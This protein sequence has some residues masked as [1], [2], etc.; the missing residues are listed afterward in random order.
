MKKVFQ[1]ISGIITY[2]LI[3]LIFSAYDH[4][5]TH[6]EINHIITVK[7][8][9]RY[10]QLSFG[11]GKFKYFT[12][13][14]NNSS[15]PNL[16]GPALDKDYYLSYTSANEPIKSL[17]PISWITQG[18]WMED[19]PWATA[20]VRH[21]YDPLAI[22]NGKKYLS[23]R[24]SLWESLLSPV[25]SLLTI[26]AET[27]VY[28]HPD[29]KYSFKKAKEYLINAL[30]ETNTAKKNEYMA[31]AYRSLGQVLHLI[32]DMGCPPHVRNDSHPPNFYAS[33]A[34]AEGLNLIKVMGDPDP[35][36]ELVKTLSIQSLVESSNPNSNLAFQF[37]KAESFKEI[38]EKLA[39]LTNQRLVTN[40]TISTTYYKQTIRPDNPYP[41]P[42]ISEN[43]YNK[44]D[45]IY[46]KN[47]D[48]INVKM[49]KDKTPILFGTTYG[50]GKPYV[51]FDCVKSQAMMIM[52]NIVEAGVNVIRQ[53]IP[54]LKIEITQAV[55]DSGGIVRGK[56]SYTIP[57]LNDEYAG[58][59]ELSN[60]YNGPVKLKIN[61]NE[62][63]VTANAV[64]NNFEI[65]LNGSFSSLK[66]GDKA[67]VYIDLGGITLKS[68]SKEFIGNLPQ[69][70]SINPTSA[71]VNDIITINGKYFGSSSTVGKV[72]FNSIVATDVVSWSDLKIEVK[73][74]T[75]AQ[76]G[77][78]YVKVNNDESNKVNFTLL[79]NKPIINS[80]TPSTAKV[81]DIIKISGDNFGDNKTNGSIVFTGAVASSTDII[82]WNNKE[83]QVKVPVNTQ[84]GDIYIIVNS[85]KSNVF[86][87]T[88]E[89]PKDV[90]KITSLSPA[91][92]IF[93]VNQSVYI[94]GEKFGTDKNKVKIELNGFLL[95]QSVIQIV[96]GNYI[97]FKVPDGAKSGKLK[98]IVDGVESNSV[99]VKIKYYYYLLNNVVYNP[100]IGVV[101]SEPT[102]YST[103]SVKTIEENSITIFVETKPGTQNPYNYTL[104]IYWDKLKNKFY[105]HDTSS[106]KI[107]GEII[108][109]TKLD[110]TYNV[111]NTASNI[112]IER[113]GSTY[114]LAS[115]G[116]SD[117]KSKQ[118]ISIRYS[119]FNS[120]TSSTPASKVTLRNFISSVSQVI[121]NI[122]VYYNFDL[123][124]EFQ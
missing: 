58:M 26:D 25:S 45:Y 113:D 36:E 24:S 109:L 87:F 112:Y 6:L 77:Y 61:S 88:L 32:A 79:D 102:G 31:L 101:V 3:V 123:Y 99:D 106:I 12:F 47:Y 118:E 110:P 19:N 44:S 100:P 71:K 35:Y 21:F 16:N 17:N 85:V 20:A 105:S 2:A 68:D 28:D 1:L 96:N 11:D 97:N 73:V 30:K 63:N 46:Y 29:N 43:D 56:I 8:L 55:T 41:Q 124:E 95:S 51:D 98:V 13:N 64:K 7:F 116:L 57:S 117:G 50:R 67:E 15:A 38:F 62:I 42:I 53:F 121:G 119:S 22:D 60:I 49:C 90:P 104:K 83:I 23:D 86:L 82:S 14:W 34:L 72:Y 94:Y 40:Q 69:I 115:F 18:G 122:N 65:K 78:V 76:T 120:I 107:S 9:E 27:W 74:P 103:R 66:K 108:S 75:N 4:E 39:Y 80:I 91:D 92:G 10:T 37:S 48:G 114:N 89:I 33:D 54:S 93:K 111:I 59:L 81:G 70:N 84:T 52:P 5:K